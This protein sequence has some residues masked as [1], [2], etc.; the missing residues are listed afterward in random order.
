MPKMR[1]GAA[2][3]RLE[4]LYAKIRERPEEMADSLNL[5]I[6]TIQLSCRKRLEFS[7]TTALTLSSVRCRLASGCP[8]NHLAVR[9]DRATITFAIGSRRLGFPSIIESGRRAEDA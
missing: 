7:A 9:V 4:V 3:R 2:A 8:D 1:T 6:N 5:Q